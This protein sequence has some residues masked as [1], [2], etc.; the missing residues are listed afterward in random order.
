MIRVELTQ[1]V[2]ND[3]SAEQVIHLREVEGSRGFPIV[4]GT[5]EALAIDRL[6]SSAPAERPL[7]HEL[8][9]NAVGLLGARITYVVID[10]VRDET[11]FAK[12][13]LRR[14]GDEYGVDARPSD[15]IA[16]AVLSTAPIYVSE[17]VMN[18]VCSA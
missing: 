1:L 12:L 13:V 17:R 16:L 3:R 6:L 8:L 2:I 15:A 10:D 5:F 18:S 14:D 9:A 11:Y 4:I 7:T